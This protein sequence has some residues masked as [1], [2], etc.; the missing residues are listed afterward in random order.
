M[1][2]AL[3]ASLAVSG[4]LIS[5][6]EAAVVSHSVLNRIEPR[7]GSIVTRPTNE[8][9]LTFNEA[10][11][12]PR[13]VVRRAASETIRGRSQ[14]TADGRTVRFIAAQNLPNG[15]YTVLWRVRSKD[16]HLVSGT[17]RFE[18]RRRS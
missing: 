15:T 16:G 18:V 12:Q 3:F 17:S 2:R 1:M 10:V 14:R 9:R 5:G 11:S 7:N 8:V 6:G 4:L 13:I